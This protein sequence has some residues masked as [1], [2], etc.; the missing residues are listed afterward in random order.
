MDDR[1]AVS[2][3]KEQ[4]PRVEGGGTME[5]EK[6][7]YFVEFLDPKESFHSILL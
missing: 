1:K 5:N 3:L 6:Q 4:T 2:C 7:Q